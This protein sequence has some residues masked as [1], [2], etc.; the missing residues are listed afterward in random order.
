MAT[1]SD[2]EIAVEDA[3]H[4]ERL[5]IWSAASTCSCKRIKI[6]CAPALS[7]LGYLEPEVHTLQVG[8]T[9]IEV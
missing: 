6:G 1:V 9:V 4:L 2:L 3:P 8:N 7:T 5:I